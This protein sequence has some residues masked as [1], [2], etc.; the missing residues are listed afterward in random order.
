MPL[1]VQL[2]VVPKDRQPSVQQEVVT[3]E[4]DPSMLSPTKQKKEKTKDRSSKGQ[5]F[6]DEP[7]KASPRQPDEEDELE[8]EEEE[9]YHPHEEG[10]VVEEVEEMDL[11]DL[12]ISRPTKK[13]GLNHSYASSHSGGSSSASLNY[14][15]G[16]S[17]RSSSITHDPIDDDFYDIQLVSTGKYSRKATWA[18]IAA[19]AGMDKVDSETLKTWLH[20]YLQQNYPKQ[21]N[22]LRLI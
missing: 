2:T 18:D 21:L 12:E 16:S 22:K 10:G 15:L 4:D 9:G 7:A 14:K 5:G 11:K 1:S 3:G 13:K 6:S 17:S 20:C 8:E 19:F